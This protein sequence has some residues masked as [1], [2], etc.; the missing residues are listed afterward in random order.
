MNAKHQAEKSIVAPEAGIVLCACNRG[1]S[2]ALL[3]TTICHQDSM[4]FTT[5]S[6]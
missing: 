5:S 6:E 4:D 1:L 2:D 3:S